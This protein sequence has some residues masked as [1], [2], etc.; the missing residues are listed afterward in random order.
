MNYSTAALATLS[1]AID[2]GMHNTSSDKEHADYDRLLDMYNKMENGNFSG[3]KS[4]R[5]LGWMQ[6]CVYMMCDDV[7]LEDMK[8]INIAA[9]EQS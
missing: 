4:A 9:K 2:H 5:W 6:A 8:Q 3:T 1:L 7:S